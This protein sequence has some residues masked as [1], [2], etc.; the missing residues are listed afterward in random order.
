MNAPRDEMQAK[1]FEQRA[2]GLLNESVTRVNA[3][4]RSRLNQARQAALE[5]A[6]A[7]DAMRR[8]WWRAA[9]FMP[10]T[11]A[12]AAVV[13]VAFIVTTHHRGGA[14]PGSDGQPVDDIEML[15]DSDAL[16]L[17]EN[18]DGGFYEWAASQGD[19]GNGGNDGTSG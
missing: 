6:A 3:R 5:E 9:A 7:A 13:L 12:V 19:D 8:P 16:D 18:Y 2:S 15:A 11:G 17:V 4:V 10:A 14:L 1:D